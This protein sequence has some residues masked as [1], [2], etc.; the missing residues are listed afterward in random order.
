MLLLN[1]VQQLGE[2][3][4]Y[5]VA[6]KQ[7]YLYF[8]EKGSIAVLAFAS[9]GTYICVTTKYQ[10]FDTVSKKE[11]F[12]SRFLR[13]WPNKTYS[14]GAALTESDMCSAGTGEFHERHGRCC[15]FQTRA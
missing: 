15:G 12:G 4:T 9:I 3:N 13:R 10:S 5:P 2:I 11:S 6:S 8:F 1:D 14:P 7:S